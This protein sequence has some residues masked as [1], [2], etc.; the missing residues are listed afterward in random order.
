MAVKAFNLSKK[1]SLMS[2]QFSPV[3]RQLARLLSQFPRVKKVLK[4]IYQ[5]LVYFQNYRSDRIN[6]SY[7]VAMVG[8]ADGATFF[9]YYDH[10]PMSLN[11]ERVLFHRYDGPTT[12]RPPND[13][14]VQIGWQSMEDG[15]IAMPFES[16]A[17]NW[18]Q[19]ARLHWITEDSFVFNDRSDDGQ[20][21][22][23]RRADACAQQITKTYDL[24]VQDSWGD[25]YFISLSYQRL[26]TVRPDYGYF[27]IPALS[28]EAINDLK[29]D[30]LFR[31]NYGDGASH[32][33]Y[34][35]QDVCKIGT[36][37][38]FSESTHY[39]NHVNIAPDGQKFVF[40]H[41]FLS[42]NQRFDRLFAGDPEGDR[43]DLL[44]DNDFVSHYCWLDETTLI[45][46]MRG[47]E[48]EDGYFAVNV[49]T[50]NIA[51]FYPDVLNGYGDGHPSIVGRQLVTDTYPGRARMQTLRH[52]FL[53]DSASGAGATA[54]TLGEFFHGF[55]FSG[56]ARCD[57]HP[58]FS[59]DGQTV[60]FDAVYGDVRRL[61]QM[62]IV[63]GD[64]R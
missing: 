50:G 27:S 3:E 8:T 20:S 36:R 19:G 7:P 60:F 1:H 59:P 31:V 29:S 24:P 63:S 17:F 55:K 9:G 51:P 32:L 26:R 41:R 61:Y 40:L 43:L 28:D 52:V 11:G 34:S 2:D 21:Y 39:F 44:V 47:P 42:G 15:T 33:L 12:N 38:S 56:E 35:L 37:P 13:A 58:R 18:Q 10:S 25:E 49:E 53:G 54:E 30:G 22:V 5:R 57:L 48:K 4:S 23:A 14:V 62:H 45:G 16:R 6:T 64:A 46:Y